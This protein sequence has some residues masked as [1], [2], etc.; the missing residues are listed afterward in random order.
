M[1]PVY[2]LVCLISYFV[3]MCSILHKDHKS[4]SNIENLLNY[5]VLDS[6]DVICFYHL[7]F[8]SSCLLYYY[9]LIF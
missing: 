2:V 4:T 3:P 1:V 8:L 6:P 5:F 9:H 7:I